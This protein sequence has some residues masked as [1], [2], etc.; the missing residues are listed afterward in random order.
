MYPWGLE[1][2]LNA[3]VHSCLKFSAVLENA[4]MRYFLGERITG[5]MRSLRYDV[6]EQL[7][8]QTTCGGLSDVDVHED[9][10]AS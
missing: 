6:T 10:G 7:H 9:D 2:T 8:L 5:C 1:F 4:Y 3:P